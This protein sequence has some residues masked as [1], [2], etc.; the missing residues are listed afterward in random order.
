[1]SKVERESH[2]HPLSQTDDGYR[3]AAPGEPADASLL[4]GPS[5]V[6]GFVRFTPDPTRTPRGPSIAP[7]VVAAFGLADRE[8]GTGLGPLASAQPIRR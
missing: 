5:N 4:I 7:A 2:E 6:G 3:L 8:F 1:M